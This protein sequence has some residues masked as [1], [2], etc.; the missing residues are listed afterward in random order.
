MNQLK[1][2]ASRVSECVMW[3]AAETTCLLGL[4]PEHA[5]RMSEEAAA[6]M[7][8]EWSTRTEN[9]DTGLCVYSPRGIGVEDRILLLIV[10]NS[11]PIDSSAAT[12]KQIL[13][14]PNSSLYKELREY[15]VEQGFISGRHKMKFTMRTC[16]SELAKGKFPTQ[17]IAP[18]QTPNQ[19]G[20]VNGDKIEVEFYYSTRPEHRASE[21]RQVERGLH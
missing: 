8:R 18:D 16:M 19:L 10:H 15:G 11:A 7:I 12:L 21:A 17:H 20:L 14:D 2:P 5:A 4:E 6:G 3:I 9:I 13:I 1:Q